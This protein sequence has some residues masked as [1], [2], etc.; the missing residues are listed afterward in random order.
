MIMEQAA[1]YEFIK[2]KRLGVVSSISAD[3]EPQSALVGIAVT[4][5][6]E[7]IFD[8]TNTSRKY[9]NLVANPACSFVVGWDG[10]QTVQFEG[11]AAQPAGTELARCQAIY[12]SVWPDG[13]ARLAWPGIA[14]FVVTPTWIRYSDYDRDP[15]LIEELKLHSQPH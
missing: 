10:E 12:F 8:T 5:Q 14:Y 9:A 4:P 2:Q 11:N 7:I 1:L 13:K 6:F 15:P 3:G